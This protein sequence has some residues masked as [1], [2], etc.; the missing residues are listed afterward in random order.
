VYRRGIKVALFSGLLLFLFF[1]SSFAQET[2][3]PLKSPERRLFGDLVKD[4]RAIWMSPKHIKGRDLRWL[5]PFVSVSAILVAEDN[6]ISKTS[7]YSPNQLSISHKVSDIGAD[8]MVGAMGA[9]YLGG[10]LAHQEYRMKTGLLGVEA[11]V[12]GE[13]VVQLLKIATDRKRPT[14]AE[15]TGFW[16]GGNSF[17]SGHSFAAWSVA[18]VL[19][20]RYPEKKWVKFSFYGLASAVSIARCTGKNH[21][22]A[23][24]LVGGG[25][26]YLVGHYIS[27]R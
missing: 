14:V 21:Y 24:V 11:L 2:E 17:P 13:V 6:H 12:S 15:G 19:S 16:A 4:Q 3:K 20:N 22:P 10:R 7:A 9:L 27:R 26:G 23:D 8:F 5:I 1:P 18:A 25:L